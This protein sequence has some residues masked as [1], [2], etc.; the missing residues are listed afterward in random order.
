[1][2]LFWR[3]IANTFGNISLVF[4]LSVNSKIYLDPDRQHNLRQRVLLIEHPNRRTDMRVATGLFVLVTGALMMT[5]ITSLAKGKEGQG[6]NQSGARAQIERGQKDL[7]RDR[8]RTRD[9]VSVPSHDRD[10][11]QDRTHAPDFAKLSDH[12]IY[13]QEVMTA[14]ERD[15]Y[16][17]QLQNAAS[18]EERRRIEAAHRHEVQV[19]AQGQGIDLA[20][21][22]Q[23]IYGGAIMSVEERNQYR[24]QLRLTGSDPE[25]KTRFMAQHQ[26]KMQQ[27]AKAQGIDLDGMTETEEAE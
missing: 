26:E 21:P 27:R 13:G 4:D 25:K 8:L 22:G 20:P 5:P 17:N 23:G 12:D 14:Q 10:R 3:K 16:R 24:E 19:R 9:R 11:I 1:L 18:S 6:A 15:A 7:D 2:G